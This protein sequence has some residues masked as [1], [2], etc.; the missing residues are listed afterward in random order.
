VLLKTIVVCET[1][2]GLV[3]FCCLVMEVSGLNCLVFT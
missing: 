1:S 2:A 3:V